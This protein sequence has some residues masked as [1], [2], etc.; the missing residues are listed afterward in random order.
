MINLSNS[1]QPPLNGSG[2][3]GGSLGKRLA[4][5]RQVFD[6]RS[7]TIFL[8]LVILAIYFQ[9]AS[10]GLFIT[11]RNITLLGRQAAL[12]SVL[13]AGATVV[14]VMREIDLSI[15]SAVFITSIVIAKLQS[16]AS[17]VNPAVAVAIGIL[18]G[19]LIGAWNAFWV[20]ICKVPSFIAT[21]AGLL[22]LRGLG[23]MWTNAATIGPLPDSFVSLTESFVSKQLSYIAIGLL[24]LL[25]VTGLTRSSR[26]A[27][28]EGEALTTLRLAVQVVVVLAIAGCAVWS[29]KGF[30]GIPT[31]LLWVM[32]IAVSLRWLL[33]NTR[34]G[35]NVYFI[36]SNREAAIYSGIN[37][38][39]HLAIAFLIMGL[40]YGVGG[41][42]LTSRLGA[43]TP[44]AGTNLELDVISA[45]VIGGV[46]LRGGLGTVAGAIS[47]GV[48]L[49]V[50]NNGFSLMNVSSFL[51]D[52]VK[53]LILLVALTADSFIRTRRK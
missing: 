23:L 16:G 28:R 42:M 40:L 32:V 7:G 3:D 11:P 46:S 2:H 1:T 4:L 41:V 8:V 27:A 35:R 25:V 52:L 43:L 51:Q 15:G 6:L 50:I 31:A 20:V 38:R 12:I 30:L 17:P 33:T 45:A 19:L 36:G 49:T 24:A 47:G 9:F 53:G 5:L 39:R 34:Y 29:V 44:S 48:L 37:V 13:A 14:M 10:N 21:L 26:L 18:A 22:A